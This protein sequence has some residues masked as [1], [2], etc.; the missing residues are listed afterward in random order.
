[1]KKITRLEFWKLR[2]AI[3]QNKTL[4]LCGPLQMFSDITKCVYYNNECKWLLLDKTGCYADE[5]L[6]TLLEK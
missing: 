5:R 3:D 4:N 1:V 2:A 6:L